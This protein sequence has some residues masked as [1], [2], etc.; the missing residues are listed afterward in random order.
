MSLR[1]EAHRLTTGD[2]RVV[3]THRTRPAAIKAAIAHAKREK[4][5]Y[6][7]HPNGAQQW[8]SFGVWDTKHRH[9][10]TG[11]HPVYLGFVDSK[12]ARAT[13]GFAR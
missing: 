11:L 3:S 2:P 5:P 10:A 4:K 13:R 1:Y 12:E 6:V 9:P 7:T 8:A